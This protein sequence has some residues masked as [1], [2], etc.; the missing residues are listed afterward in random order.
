MQNIE[1]KQVKDGGKFWLFFMLLV[2]LVYLMS[3]MQKSAIPG[4]LF[5]I[6]RADFSAQPSQIAAFSSVFMIA[7]SVMQLLMGPLTARYNPL[8]ITLWGTPFLCVGAVVLPFC[9][10][11]L[12]VYACRALIAIGCSCV[13]ISIVLGAVKFFPQSHTM[14]LAVFMLIGYMGNVLGGA[15]V[16]HA[17]N[18][19]GWRSLMLYLAIITTCLYLL[20]A[21]LLRW[22]VPR[23]ENPS[24]PSKGSLLDF[25][26]Y[27]Q[28]LKNPQ[29]VFLC[30]TPVFYSVFF[31]Y[32]VVVGPKFLQD[33]C[34][35]SGEKAGVV[36]SVM[37]FLGCISGLLFASVNRKLGGNS[38]AF[39]QKLSAVVFFVCQIV[40]TVFI[41]LGIHSAI[42]F[43]VSFLAFGVFANMAPIGISL[44]SR[45]NSEKLLGS[46]F[47][48][49]NSITFAYVS[50]FGYACG[51]ILN[52][53][54][55]DATTDVLVYGRDA[56]LAIFA[57]FCILAIPVLLMTHCLKEFPDQKP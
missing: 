27:W 10:Q 15:P 36:A 37:Q 42:P 22:K 49:W 5:D 3:N 45:H 17:A 21:V 40:M 18:R 29:N 56:Y 46:A 30:S 35:L 33:F 26:V 25:S 23:Q 13:T 57:F 55:P 2:S 6:L 4:C 50:L 16:L 47:S 41:C 20:W 43:V 8:S 39:L 7:Y 34:G 19:L 28:V 48:V 24:T 14:K 51:L 53:F 9:H 54:T 12:L 44:L 38:A 52:C 31:C 1:E 11:L 32:A